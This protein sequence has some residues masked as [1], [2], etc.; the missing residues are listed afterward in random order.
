ME[1]V[2]DEDWQ[3]LLELFPMGWEQTA[4][5]SGALERLRGFDSAGNLLRVLLLHVGRGYSLR[6]SAVRAREAGLADV[7]DVAILKRLRKA[8]EWWRQM[9]VALLRESG[10][11]MRAEARGWKVRAMDGTLIKEPGS[12]GTLWRVH[13]SLLL[14]ELECDHLELTPVKGSGTGE[15]MERFP[16]APGDLMLADRG[17]CRPGSIAALR[18]QG[19]AVIVRLNTSSLPLLDAKGKRFPLLD[20]LE[21]M[22]TRSRPA[23]WRVWT[24]TG[25]ELIEG[26]LCALRKSEDSTRRAR[27]K[28]TRK[29][30]QGGPE[31]KPE[32][33]VYA[34]YVMVFTTL[35][36]EQFTA[37]EVLECYR[38]RWQIELVFK[39]LKSLA[40]IGNLPKYDE[41]SARGWLYGKLLL[42]LLGQKLM[43]IG[44]DISPW[45]YEIPPGGSGERVAAI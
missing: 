14:P 2:L 30:Q 32:T 21:K 36:R 4:V 22:G 44:R 18:R 34:G 39:R 24:R 8:G 45:G 35:P 1:Q 17:Y 42:A 29:A 13:Y 38:L 12:G 25:T 5:L 23:E 33:L 41:R 43:R 10:F 6:E 19:A 11:A 15:K 40:G 26:R 31:P 28:I 3:L 16:A 9:C 27:R 37:Q 20:R 7:S